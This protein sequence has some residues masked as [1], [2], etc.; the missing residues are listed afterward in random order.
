MKN[1]TWLFVS[2]MLRHILTAVS[3]YFVT[4]G[5]ISGDR[6]QDFI[7]AVIF[8]GTVGWSWWQKRGQ[9][10]LARETEMLKQQLRLHAVSPQRPE[11][12]RT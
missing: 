11:R 3:G 4:A 12:E 5:V 9:V 8:V 7:A 1:E 2:G 10:A 6:Q